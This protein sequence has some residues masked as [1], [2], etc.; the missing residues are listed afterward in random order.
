M[1]I[2]TLKNP[3]IIVEIPHQRP[4]R[5]WIAHTAADI[6][7]AGYAAGGDNWEWSDDPT[8]DDY[9][10]AL[11]HDLHA[12]LRLTTGEALTEMTSY[13]GHQDVRVRAEIERVLRAE[14]IIAED[15][16]DEDDEECE[17]A[18]GGDA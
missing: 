16:D 17:S 7:R 5:A 13:V 12:L 15:V 18:T 14:R 6:G 11:G 4:A 1:D 3:C 2:P 8:L 9:V 10:E